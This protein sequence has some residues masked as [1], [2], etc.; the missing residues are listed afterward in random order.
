MTRRAMGIRAK[1]LLALAF[2]LGFGLAVLVLALRGFLLEGFLRTE[3]EQMREAHVLAAGRAEFLLDELAAKAADYAA[4]D[5]SW[6][7]LE[8]AGPGYYAYHFS[9]ARFATN[10]LALVAFVDTRSHLAAGNSY[11]PSAQ[12]LEPL[13]G[14]FLEYLRIHPAFL[15]P[16]GPRDVVKGIVP[17][18]IRPL[19]LVSRPIVRNDYTGPI[20]G[21]LLLGEYL[22]VDLLLRVKTPERVQTIIYPSAD[23]HLP[24]EVRGA[25]AALI[26]GAEIFI[27]RPNAHLMTGYSLLRDFGGR[28][29]FVLRMD[30]E[31]NLYASGLLSL[32]VLL[33]AFGVLVL[34]TAGVYV[35]LLELTVLRRVIRLGKTVE[36]VGGGRSPAAGIVDDGSDEIG[37]LTAQVRE[38]FVT[39][40]RLQGELE[41][42]KRTMEGRVE[43]RTR[44][45]KD[46]I[47]ALGR[48]VA[49]RREAEA[50]VRDLEQQQRAVIDNM[51]GG[52]VTFDDRLLITRI[53]P[54]A[55]R[56]LRVA[57][58]CIGRPLAEVLPE[59]F[60][61][62][63]TGAFQSAE[64]VISRKEIKVMSADGRDLVIGFVLS[65][66]AP[67]EGRGAQGIVLFRDLTDERRLAAEQ[68]RL[69]R[70]TTLGEFSAQVTHEL[71]NPLT[72]MS[73]TVQYL[74]ASS[75]GRDREMLRIIIESIERMEGIIRRMRLLSREMPLARTAIDLADLVAHLLLF[76]ETSLRAQG[77]TPV[78]RAPAAP[79]LVT[80]D[81][82]QL[83]QALLNLLMN[84][85]QAMPRGGRL[86]V[87]LGRGRQPADGG[88]VPVM[89][90]I[91]D[92]G[93][94]ITPEAAGRI[95]DPFYTTREAGTG[96]GLPIADKI[97]REHGGSIRFASRPGHGACF[98]VLLPA[99]VP[100]EG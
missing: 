69:N 97:V 91:A 33:V 29:A 15:T 7:F 23:S 94:G 95:F 68:Q 72:A 70:L 59:A 87:R 81:P 67:S 62:D 60:A 65:R 61:A 56:L 93:V 83:H 44:D 53:N 84:A 6:H 45:L 13:T 88:P 48:E 47:D 20:H 82:A 55:Q 37:G 75:E 28:P 73:S 5:D 26:Q 78:F 40:Q 1:T 92:T 99:A 89:L 76:L 86:R 18:G 31:R 96:L 66:I 11:N 80:G 51:V 36:S 43:E 16:G 74:A 32:N 34:A 90:L 19:L 2:T 100:G 50:Q 9:A 27:V 41:E 64:P 14:D 49:V 3:T 54:A 21:T 57:S 39:Q 38:A 85:M 8:G 77:I 22:E 52:L 63:I 58:P 30:L 71:R 98:V 12:A 42:G 35:L 79:V 25:K 17:L 10:R 24:A 46:T 4:N